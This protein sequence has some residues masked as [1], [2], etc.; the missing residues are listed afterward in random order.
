[1]DIKNCFEILELKL[2][3]TME[4]VK[5]AYRKLMMATHPDKFQGNP[6][7]KVIAER[8]SKEINRARE[9]LFAYHEEPK[10]DDNQNRI[11]IGGGESYGKVSEFLNEICRRSGAGGSFHLDLYMVYRDWC[12][13]NGLC[14]VSIDDLDIAL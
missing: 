4:Q 5:T 14:A 13:E 3:A 11:I 2:D 9:E 6:K 1:M 10:R 7:L 12:T 8:R